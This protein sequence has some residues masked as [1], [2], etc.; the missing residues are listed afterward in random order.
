MRWGA[1]EKRT[2][3]CRRFAL[4]PERCEDCHCHLW[5]EYYYIPRQ[6]TMIEMRCAP[7]YALR[8]VKAGREE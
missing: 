7:C 3:W 5:L 4:T 1:H 6:F 8:I 2:G